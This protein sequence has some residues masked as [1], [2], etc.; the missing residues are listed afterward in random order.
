M[1]A[2]RNVGGTVS[3]QWN[4]KA[5]HELTTKLDDLAAA[6]AGAHAEITEEVLYRIVRRTPVLSGAARGNWRTAINSVDTRVDPTDVDPSG[7]N[8]VAEAHELL[9]NLRS[10]DTTTITNGL[11]YINRLEHGWSQK[12]PAGM[13]A[14]TVAEIPFIVQKAADG[15]VRRLHGEAGAGAAGVARGAE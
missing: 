10:G 12:A 11:P 4:G 15:F 3:I 9:R 14:I 13:V 8:V 1:D 5:F 2:P 7:L 6:G